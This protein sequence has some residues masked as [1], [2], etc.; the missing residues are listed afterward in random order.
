[1]NE[2]SVGSNAAR[3]ATKTQ[4]DLIMLIVYRKN[5]YLAG[6]K[7]ITIEG[8]ELVFLVKSPNRC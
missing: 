6:C 4:E 1:M 7:I 2:E 8:E 3:W 5:L